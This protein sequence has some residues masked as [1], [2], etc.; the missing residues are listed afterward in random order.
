MI[1]NIITVISILTFSSISFSQ[2]ATDFKFYDNCSSEI[3]MLDYEL[4]YPDTTI[5]SKDGIARINTPGDYLLS[6][7]II[8]DEI[9]CFYNFNLKIRQTISDTLFLYN[10]ALC[11][12][13]VLHTTNNF[14]YDCNQKTEGYLEV[15]DKNGIVRVQG[16]FKNGWPQG[17]LKFYNEESEIVSTEVHR[18]GKLIKIK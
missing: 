17:K 3:V 7:S 2:I 1:K 14:Y 15:R 18:N 9:T 12:D 4:Y 6:T 13:G 16:K 11:N 8:R 10:I 5:V